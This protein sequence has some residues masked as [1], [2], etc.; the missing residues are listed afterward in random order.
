MNLV[1]RVM[2]KAL[3]GMPRGMVCQDEEFIIWGV[4]LHDSAPRPSADHGEYLCTF[5]HHRAATNTAA[6]LRRGK[7]EAVCNEI[8]D[9][10]VGTYPTRR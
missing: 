6:R 10:S 2:A 4:G 1:V 8:S 5:A 3:R 9:S 7:C